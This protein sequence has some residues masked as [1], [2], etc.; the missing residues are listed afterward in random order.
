M[1]SAIR[2]ERS[3]SK[4]S[5]TSHESCRNSSVKRCSVGSMLTKALEARQVEVEVRLELKQDRPQLLAEAERRVDNQV[6]RLLFDGEPLDVRDVAAA[7]DR[8]HEAG[9]GLLPPGF[10]PFSRRLPVERVVELDRVEVLRVEGEVLSCRHLFRIEALA[11]VGTTS[12]NSRCGC[13]LPSLT[14]L[15]KRVELRPR[16]RLARARGSSRTWVESR[17]ADHRQIGPVS[18]RPRAPSSGVDDREG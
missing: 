9:R 12:P 10:E 14:I 7:L 3:N 11:P 5:G 2:W 15:R 16:G 4:T 8:E 13:R 6:D 17:A 1:Q 18:T